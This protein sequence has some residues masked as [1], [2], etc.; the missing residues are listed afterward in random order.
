[1][2]LAQ[3]FPVPEPWDLVLRMLAAAALGGVVGLEREFSDQPAGLRTHILVSLGAA[4]FTMAGA[5]GVAPFLEDPPEQLTTDPGRVAAQ[6][7]TGIGFLGAGAIIRQ[8]VN[9]KGL[10][11]AAALWVTAAIGT[12]AALG[13]WIGAFATAAITVTTLYGL[14]RLERGLLRRRRRWRYEFGIDAH[15]DL[16]FSELAR[17]IEEHRG[18]VLTMR[19]DTDEQGNRRLDV[20][21]DL[22]GETRPESLVDVVSVVN[23]VLN[24]EWSR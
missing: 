19:M 8:G 23:G 4:L 21:V 12:A 7:V 9:I 14:K 1:V 22:P 20:V 17:A 3:G 16:K 6:V 10:T 2:I 11:T 18:K 13:F 5:F 24:V 15:P